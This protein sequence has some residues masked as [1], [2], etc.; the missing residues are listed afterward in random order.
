M[1]MKPYED[2]PHTADWALRVRGGTAAELFTNAALGMYDL[3]DARP[4]SGSPEAKCEI[5]L[6]ALD[7]ESLLVAWLNELLYHTESEGTAYD[8]FEIKRLDTSRLAAS[9][10]GG[11]AAGLKKQIKAVTFHNLRIVETDDGLE[12]TIVFDV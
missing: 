10:W 6:E 7:L 12:T 1:I 9:A 11:P 2:V 4:R 3:M 8:R 5:A